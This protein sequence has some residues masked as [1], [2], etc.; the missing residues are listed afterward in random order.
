MHRVWGTQQLERGP[1]AH[2]APWRVI[3]P[4]TEKY[5]STDL[6]EMEEQDQR[7]RYGKFLSYEMKVSE[8]ESC[9]VTGS[10]QRASW[11][12]NSGAQAGLISHRWLLEENDLTLK[13][14]LNNRSLFYFYEPQINFINLTFPNVSSAQHMGAESDWCHADTNTRGIFTPLL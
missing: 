10:G 2:F 9:W 7:R 6:N 13:K 1:T 12:A 5:S 11:S 14:A 3:N 8:H 4:A